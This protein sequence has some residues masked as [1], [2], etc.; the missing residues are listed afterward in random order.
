MDCL[1]LAFPF[2]RVSKVGCNVQK[3]FLFE[4]RSFLAYLVTKDRQESP[5]LA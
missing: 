5:R 1:D 3:Y 4:F 2:V